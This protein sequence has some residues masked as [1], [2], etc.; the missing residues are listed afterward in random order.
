MNKYRVNV[1]IEFD[2]E[3]D[4]RAAAHIALVDA[5][6]LAELSGFDLVKVNKV[7]RAGAP[8]QVHSWSLN[9]EPSVFPVGS[10]GAP[11]VTDRREMSTDFPGKPFGRGDTVTIVE[12]LDE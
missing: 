3:A 2:V 5:L 11:H 9:V 12:S 6:S 4:H 1:V 7:A 8:V 10:D